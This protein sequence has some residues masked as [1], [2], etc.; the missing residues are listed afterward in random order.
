MPIL[1]MS[2]PNAPM[3]DDIHVPGPDVGG[4]AVDAVQGVADLGQLDL[5]LAGAGVVSL[6]V[7]RGDGRL[8]VGELLAEPF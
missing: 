5:G 7:Q 4:A 3:L 8:V 6:A 1:T 2:S